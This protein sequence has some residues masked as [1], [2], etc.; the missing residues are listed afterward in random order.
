MTIKKKKIKNNTSFKPAITLSLIL[1]SLVQH[2]DSNAGN[3]KVEYYL[4]PKQSIKGTKI[5]DNSYKISSS[6]SSVISFLYLKYIF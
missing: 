4:P 3:I 2:K 5:F 1:L 6:S